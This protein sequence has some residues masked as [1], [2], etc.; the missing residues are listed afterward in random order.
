ML[1]CLAGSLSYGFAALWGRRLRS[2]PPLTAA[3]CQLVASTA[4]LAVLAAVI[5]RPWTLPWPTPHAVLALIALAALATS[6][7]YVIFYRI[8]ALSG[9]S[10]VMLVTLLIPVTGIGLGVSVLGET[11]EPRHVAGALIIASGLLVIDG[12]LPAAAAR[13]LRQS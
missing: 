6:L 2:T 8:L 5:D 9:P 11:L 3:T 4:V 13:L 10:N 12:R 7:A 1:L